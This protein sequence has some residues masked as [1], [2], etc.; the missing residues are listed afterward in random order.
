MK[1]LLLLPTVDF[2]CNVEKL[3]FCCFAQC[4]I[5][6]TVSSVMTFIDVVLMPRGSISQIL[7]VSFAFCIT[8]VCDMVNKGLKMTIYIF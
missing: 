4:W 7:R 2:C 3:L 8:L 1:V 6:V 5:V